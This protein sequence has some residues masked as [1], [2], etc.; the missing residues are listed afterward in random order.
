[1]AKPLSIL[2]ISKVDSQISNLKSIDERS[3]ARILCEFKQGA[4]KDKRYNYFPIWNLVSGLA[5]KREK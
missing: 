4:I 5:V 3:L 2:F 1:M